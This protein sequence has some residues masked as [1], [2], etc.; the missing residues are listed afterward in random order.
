L[1]SDSSSRFLG[2][3]G[4]NFS[5]FRKAISNFEMRDDDKVYELKCDAK[6][7]LCDGHFKA[8]LQT[9]SKEK[10]ESSIFADINEARDFVFELDGSCGYHYGMKKLSF[11]EIEYPEWDL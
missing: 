3:L 10:P 8:D 4:G 5:H 7:D 1:R 9:L 6:D 11:Q 2:F